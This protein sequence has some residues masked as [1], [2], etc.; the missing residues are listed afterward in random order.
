MIQAAGSVHF[1]AA[2][3]EFHGDAVPTDGLKFLVR[4]EN[5]SGVCAAFEAVEHEDSGHARIAIGDVEDYEVA[6]WCVDA[7]DAATDDGR[8][9]E[10]G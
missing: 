10:H 4:A 8:P 2:P 6:V 5:V 3:A 7:F 9:A 1:T